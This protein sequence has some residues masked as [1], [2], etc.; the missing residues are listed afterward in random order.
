MLPAALGGAAAAFVAFGAYEAIKPYAW[1]RIML[2]GPTGYISKAVDMIP[3]VKDNA[4]VSADLKNFA[5]KGLA[6]GTIGGLAFL[7]SSKKKGLGL[8]DAKLAGSAVG[9]ASIVYAVQFLGEINTLNLGSVFTNIAQGKISNA[10]NAFGGPVN[11]TLGMAMNN[12][13]LANNAVFRG[14]HNALPMAGAHNMMGV[15]NYGMGGHGAHNQMM[16]AN[17]AAIQRGTGRSGFF[18]AKGLG[19]SR[20][21]LF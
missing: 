5:E 15:H 3:V 17:T 8:V 10:R 16:T 20:V 2:T 6:L 18:G 14:A 12:N 7:V 9:L 11:G 21:N 19:A 1:D 13:A 4:N